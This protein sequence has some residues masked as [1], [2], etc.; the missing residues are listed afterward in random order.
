MRKI[1]VIFQTSPQD[2]DLWN[3]RAMSNGHERERERGRAS[4]REREIFKF[5]QNVVAV[6]QKPSNLQYL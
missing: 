6:G 5:H 4:E 2:L 3:Q 1:H